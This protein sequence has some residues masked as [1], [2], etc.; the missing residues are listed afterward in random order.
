MRGEGPSIGRTGAL[1]QPGHVGLDGSDREEQPIGDQLEDRILTQRV[2]IVAVLVAEA[3]L[4]HAL[5]H[6]LNLLPVQIDA[7]YRTAEAAKDELTARLQRLPGLAQEQFLLGLV[8]AR[9]AQS[10]PWIPLVMVLPALLV[11]Y[12]RRNVKDAPVFEENRKQI[13]KAAIASIWKPDMIKT[14]LLASMLA[15]VIESGRRPNRPAPESR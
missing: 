6:L 12:V 2:V 5:P 10:D 13:D 15:T 1:E 7:L 14:T 4:V 9:T 8:T 11:F 3:D